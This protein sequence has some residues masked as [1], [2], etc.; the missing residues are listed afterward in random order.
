MRSI[1]RVAPVALALMLAGSS[2]AHAQSAKIAY[3]N[4]AALLQNAPGRE[5]AEATLQRESQG[6][7][8]QL[9]KMSDSLNSMIT[10]FT[11]AEPTLSAPVKETQTKAIQALETDLQARQ[12]QL[13]QQF[14]ARQTEL[15]APIRESV[16]KVLDDIRAE[17]GYAVIFANDPQQSVVLS[18][19]KN[20]DITER[21]VARLRTVAARNPAP[22]ALP[23]APAAK[24][25]TPVSAPSGVTR[26]KPP[27]R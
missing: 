13:Q 11:K 21:V 12:L 7:Q 27:A 23:S 8:A 15:M 16:M 20:L 26:T 14:A 25:G 17:D 22:G 24:T 19:D 6:F 10:K 4:T 5:A 18:A 1:A 3:V 9:Q 2:V